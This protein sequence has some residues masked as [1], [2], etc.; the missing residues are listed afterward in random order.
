VTRAAARIGALGA[1]R[2]L[3]EKSGL[4]RRFAHLLRES[5]GDSET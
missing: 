5:D 2:E 1:W 4:G 3:L